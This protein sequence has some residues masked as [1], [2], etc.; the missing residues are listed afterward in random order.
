M[1]GIIRHKIM[2][3]TRPRALITSKVLNLRLPLLRLLVYMLSIV[4]SSFVLWLWPARLHD[5][6]LALLEK[7]QIYICGRLWWV[8]SYSWVFDCWAARLNDCLLALFERHEWSYVHPLELLGLVYR[9]FNLLLL[10]CVV[11]ECFFFLCNRE[12]FHVNL[13]WVLVWYAQR[14]SDLL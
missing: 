6:L 1:I 9:A 11:S 8:I 14:C 2:F 3:K 5:C 4:L 7:H 10:V 13:Y 12:F